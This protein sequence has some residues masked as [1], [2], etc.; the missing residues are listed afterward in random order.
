M[1]PGSPHASETVAYVLQAA[2]EE[3]V[4]PAA[5]ERGGSLREFFERVLAHF[6]EGMKRLFGSDS[7]DLDLQALADV[8]WTAAAVETSSTWQGARNSFDQA[9]EAFVNTGEGSQM[10]GWGL[11]VADNY[12][13]GEGYMQDRLMEDSHAWRRKR[14]GLEGMPGPEHDPPSPAQ[15]HAWAREQQAWNG[16]ASEMQRF[17]YML[18][19]MKSLSRG[20]GVVVPALN[21]G[22]PLIVPA[23]EIDVRR[24]FD[25]VPWTDERSDAPGADPYTLRV[26]FKLDPNSGLNPFQMD[27]GDLAWLVPEGGLREEHALPGLGV[28]Q[29][30]VKTVD[31]TNEGPR[32]VFTL[33]PDAPVIQT[34]RREM[35]DARGYPVHRSSD[36]A[37]HRLVPLVPDSALLNLDPVRGRGMQSDGTFSRDLSTDYGRVVAMFDGAMARAE[38]EA[39]LAGK[40]PTELMRNVFAT[41]RRQGRAYSED[42]N[43]SRTVGRHLYNDFK[44]ALSASPD[45]LRDAVNMVV[46]GKHRRMARAAMDDWA[47]REA[48][49]KKEGTPG[50]HETAYDRRRP[51]GE[52]LAS[53]L[54]SQGGVPGLIYADGWSR[55]GPD[56][57]VA[58]FNRVIF[59]GSDLMTA[60]RVRHGDSLP[61]V[62]NP[63]NRATSVQQSRRG[64]PRD[65]R[66]RQWQGYLR[67]DK[68]P[69]WH[70]SDG[71][72][73]ISLV[74]GEPFFGYEGGADKEAPTQAW[75]R[76]DKTDDG[77]AEVPWETAPFGLRDE[78]QEETVARMRKAVEDAV[79][80]ILGVRSHPSIIV[81]ETKEEVA[82]RFA[83]WMRDNMRLKHVQA[84]TDAELVDT[85][86]R[87]SAKEVAGTHGLGGR[88]VARIPLDSLAKRMR[89]TGESARTIVFHE[90][91]G[92]GGLDA[93]L[94]EAQMDEL[95]GIIEGWRMQADDESSGPL[96][97]EARI[98]RRAAEGFPESDRAYYRAKGDSSYKS[99]V[100]MRFL[101]EAANRV[102]TE[103][104]SHS[105]RRL[106]DLVAKFFR[107]ALSRVY[108][109]RRD[110]EITAED[111]VDLAR[112]SAWALRAPG[113]AFYHVREDSAVAA[114]AR[115]YE[116][117]LG[118]LMEETADSIADG[119]ADSVPGGALAPDT[120]K[121]AAT[122]RDAI[123][124]AM[125]PGAVQF[126]DDL[127]GYYRK[128]VGWTKFL[129]QFVDENRGGIPA[130]E[131]WHAHLA[132]MEKTRNETMDSVHKTVNRHLTL[133]TRKQ[134]EVN[135]F[136][137]DSTFTQQWG[138]DPGFGRPVQISPAMAKRFK[139][140]DETQKGV[141]RDVFAHGEN[142]RHV[143]LD[144]A[145]R[146]GAN[147]DDRMTFLPSG[148]LTGPY[149]PLMRFG[150]YAAELKSAELQRLE[151]I[152]DKSRALA[153]RIG[154]MK[155]DERHYVV[156]FF[157]TLG[158]AR[159]FADENRIEN[160]GR[161][162]FAQASERPPSADEAPA[163]DSRLIEKV[164]G[165]M[166]ADESAELTKEAR[167]AFRGIL[168][169]VYFLEMDDRNARMAGARRRNRHGFDRD[170]MRAFLT[171]AKS[172]ARLVSRMKHGRDVNASFMDMRRQAAAGGDRSRTQDA[173]NMAARHYYDTLSAR[174]TP[175]QDR[176]AGLNSLYMLTTSVGYH[177]TNLTQPVMVTVPKLAGDFGD[178]GKAWAS[179]LRGY[180][181]AA[182]VVG[183]RGGLRFN[184]EVEVGNA[185]SHYQRTLLDLQQ[186]GLLDVG[187]EE[188]LGS[189]DETPTGYAA[190]DR[191]LG[192]LNTVMHHLYQVARWVEAVNRVAA[193]VAA[194]DMASSPGSARRLGREPMD[195]A[196]HVVQSTQ[197][198]FTRM[199]APLLLKRFPF[200]KVTMQY[201]KFVVMMAWLFAGA[202]RKSFAGATPQER[203]AGQRTLLLLAAHGGLFG[204]AT[205]IPGMSS[206]A[207]LLGLFLGDEEPEDVETWIRENVEDEA[208]AQLLSRGAPSLLGLDMSTKLSLD[209]LYHPVPYAD[210]EL[211]PDGA[212]DL[213][214]NMMGPLGGTLANFGR[215]AAYMSR[216]DVAK[217][218]E[219][220]LP[221]GLRSAL[222]AH[223][224]GTEGYSLPNGDVVLDP[225][226]F[227][228]LD[229][230][231]SG[232]GLHATEI[233]TVKWRRGQQFE[234]ERWV[235][236]RTT[237]V[238]RKYVAARE[239]GDRA[240][241]DEAFREWRDLQD[242][243]DRIRPLFSDAPDALRRQGVGDL[244]R[245]WNEMR[246]RV[247]RGRG[248]MS[249]ESDW[250]DDQDWMDGFDEAA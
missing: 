152:P 64:L 74:M 35:E 216:G 200:A 182:M 192:G 86:R 151:A 65:D 111:V 219:Y 158:A 96:P 23:Y 133:T 71:R 234:M 103:P 144:L 112:M 193:A 235:S 61:R 109:L 241:I 79:E 245:A 248:R 20:G 208:L 153:G 101:G 123:R 181:V 167:D 139:A 160:G 194:Q 55:G 57:P 249:Y 140:L 12:V 56:S 95:Y 39:A 67:T 127:G 90:V 14:A 185:P 60:G 175:I 149:A 69:D 89:R 83:R 154:K 77:F 183:A 73:T 240:G 85:A 180:R 177:F 78:T 207:W 176:I 68:R 198:D 5:L 206:F 11:Y 220:M 170:M 6:K 169:Q 146:A 164:L 221:K 81:G 54:L 228:L 22:T 201:K 134:D 147:R 72:D 131:E 3:G 25:V 34:V 222:E 42:A 66:D 231:V 80:A 15:V 184:A 70:F 129:H 214:F 237:A 94:T 105:L 17:A 186:R 242:A 30:D 29:F 28:D 128:A 135:E 197:G 98:A 41:V 230:M 87:V 227:D 1:D 92:H 100:V 156:S 138:Y 107:G 110:P 132:A 250:P 108:D 45:V 195:Y 150:S 174:D 238:R 211:S 16:V 187:M 58:T 143:K 9:D 76:G 48:A 136:I 161:Y 163:R 213:V 44:G 43:T 24:M 145:K 40:A 88:G 59:R 224:L 116:E 117:N 191:A 218:V 236:E 99:E 113:D 53:M 102:T 190:A 162:A 114:H 31:I 50:F 157:D 203:A 49:L 47:A 38:E 209:Q 244:K 159:R 37:L 93:F 178:Y 225:R 19:G 124:T 62:R 36:A 115:P 63:R 46:D 125:G 142:M 246:R 173:F 196:R 188:D 75:R 189:F 179:L 223:R 106:L 122:T 7:L 233:A 210:L 226:E 126:H 33:K 4:T 119:A 205:G 199:G 10:E 215:G 97:Q 52:M 204:G 26:R 82:Q 104:P 91:A 217:G 171:R 27:I 120:A 18:Q 13:V 141:V 202:A 229:L 243:K 2:V 8:A 32:E 21:D 84:A 137:A 51:L 155:S 121:R 172:E 247:R 148:S 168:T 166:G 212:K 165:F 239:A 118:G 232:L 130:M